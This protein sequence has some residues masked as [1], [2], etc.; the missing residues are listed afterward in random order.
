[1][2]IRVLTTTMCACDTNFPV[3]L[4][5]FQTLWRVHHIIACIRHGSKQLCGAIFSHPKTK[6]MFPL[7]VQH[8]FFTVALRCYAAWFFT[9]IPGKCVK[10]ASS[11]R[12]LLFF[13]WCRHIWRPAVATFGVGDRCDRPSEK[14]WSQPLSGCACLSV[15]SNVDLGDTF[16]SDGQWSLPD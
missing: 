7:W 16:L 3:T 15:Q 8:A 2:F 14:W 5:S 10:H 13:W 12:R 11:V 4:F 1:M 9:Q 6:F